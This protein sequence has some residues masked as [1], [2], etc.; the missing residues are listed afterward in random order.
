MTVDGTTL[1]AA[2]RWLGIALLAWGAALAATLFPQFVPRGGRDQLWY[3]A[4]VLMLC[5]PV[6]VLGARRPG[7]A[8]WTWFVM[9]PLVLVMEWPAVAQ[10]GTELRPGPLSLELPTVLGFALVLTMGCGNYFGTRFTFVAILYAAAPMAIV[11]SLWNRNDKLEATEP[12]TF[13]ANALV[14]TVLLIAAM[15]SIRASARRRPGANESGGWNAVWLDFRDLFGIVWAKR[16]MDRIN[17]AAR[18][19]RWP[20]RLTL[21]G[22]TTAEQQDALETAAANERLDHWM[23]LLLKRFVDP[24]WIEARR[25]D[26]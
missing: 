22:I 20:I 4:A 10:M 14:G 11:F 7:S 15:A 1:V 8:S 9:L 3:A 24:E 16:V 18:S 6:A 21:D 17:E 13:G 2:R 5:P 26:Q 12:A 23:R 19:E 25:S